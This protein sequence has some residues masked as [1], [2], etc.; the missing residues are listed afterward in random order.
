MGDKIDYYLLP[1]E[2]QDSYLRAVPAAEAKA[3]VLI[4]HSDTP[5]HIRANSN[6][7]VNATAS[8]SNRFNRSIRPAWMELFPDQQLLLIDWPVMSRSVIQAVASGSTLE[9]QEKVF[10]PL[11][12]EGQVMLE[13][14]WWWNLS[15]II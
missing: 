11:D 5:T 6:V 8:R 14:L 13:Y 2:L 15:T 4:T 1:A 7:S 12:I 10:S 9:Q 3:K